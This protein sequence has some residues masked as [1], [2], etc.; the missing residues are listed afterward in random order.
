VRTSSFTLEHPLFANRTGR[1]VRVA[2]I[3]SGIHTANPHITRVS[4]GVHLTTEGED[5]D[6][7][8]LLGHGT[9]I[10]A[11]I[12]EKAPATE[13]VA[14]RVFERTLATSAFILSRAIEWAAAQ[15][16]R[17]IN[18]SLGTPKPERADV[19]GAAVAQATATGSLVVSAKELNGVAWFPGSLAGVVGVLQDDDCARDEMSVDLDSSPALLCR[20]S[21]YPRPIPGVPAERNV[22]GISFAV[23]NTTGFLARL[24]ES[25]PDLQTTDDLVRVMR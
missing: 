11:A 14:V 7:T 16:C 20:A 25:D 19:L 1:G 9:A 5:A 2:V 12:L 8:D 23:A 18:L 22:R 13:L 24:L 15:R 21:G 6:F 4:F 10:A 17:L 3:D